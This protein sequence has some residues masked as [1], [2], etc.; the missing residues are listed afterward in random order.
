MPFS[1]QSQKIRRRRRVLLW[2]SVALL[3][4]AAV[5]GIRELRSPPGSIGNDPTV[6]FT[7]TN[8]RKTS[9]SER[10][11]WPLY[12]YDKQRTR[13]LAASDVRPPFKR[14]WKKGGNILLEFPPVL[15]GKT[16]FLLKN[17]GA[18]YA[19]SKTTGRGRWRRKLGALAASSPA[20]GHGVTYVVLLARKNKRSAG[21]VVAVT[22]GGRTRWS[23]K[24]SS[25]AESSPLLHSG[26][27]YF[28]TEGGSVL[29]LRSRDGRPLWT[30]RAAGAVK[31]G[32]AYAN[33]RL[34]FGDY[35]GRVHC[36]R[37]RDGRRIWSRSSGDGPFGSGHF[38]STP[39]LAYGRLYIGS[40]DGR[41]YSLSART[42]K[43]AWAKQTGGYVYASPAV[44]TVSGERPTVYVGSYNGTFYALDARTGRIRW[45]YR[46]GGKISGAAS[47]IGKTVYFSDLAKRR[48]IG[49]A[50]GSGRRVFSYPS[51]AFNPAISDGRSLYLTG[52]AGLY[53]LDPS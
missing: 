35:G 6:E 4:A 19:I 30:Y 10:A 14:R 8:L 36:V 53:R 9:P 2:G 16:L 17:N 32:P 49:L 7:E 41:L 21:R 40:T 44:A 5:V 28:G 23:R 25:R 46:S 47:V 43:I 34:Y 29:A 45:S 51:G 50:T 22:G 20:Y 27:L 1:P 33:G 37:A 48:T 3:V 38:Y 24:L 52:Y 31:G 18:L 15:G 11:N 39:A 13:Y 26:R 12:G 42:G